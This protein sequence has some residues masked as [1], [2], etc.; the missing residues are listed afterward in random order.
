[1]SNRERPILFSGSMVRAIL[2]GN[3]TQ[4]RRVVKRQRD[5]EFD[6]HDPHYGPYW[7]SYVAGSAEGD[8]A[9]VRCPYGK[10]G[11]RVWVRE[12][13]GL[14]NDLGFCDTSCT[15]LVGLPDDWHLAYRADHIDPKHGDGP[16][17][18]VWR[19]SIFM[20]RWASRI[21][22]EITDV[23]VEPLQQ[24]SEADAREEG[25]T[26]HQGKWW[27]GSPVIHGKWTGPREAYQALWESINGPESWDS[28]PWV[29]AVKFRLL[30]VAS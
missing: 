13:W 16:H 15:G 5:M 22:L 17:R 8:D 25:V 7:L 18:P 28:N 6:L 27:D 20:P 1:M 23:R 11:G 2:D 19:P 12:A 29:W 10:L 26:D 30:E 3:K 14:F 9:K 24:I 4:T 21:T